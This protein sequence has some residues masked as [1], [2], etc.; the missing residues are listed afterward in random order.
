VNI[1]AVNT[2]S[3]AKTV[4]EAITTVRVVARA[5]PSGFRRIVAILLVASG[6]AL[7]LR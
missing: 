2:K 4:N 7:L 1:N 3:S 5:T 6:G